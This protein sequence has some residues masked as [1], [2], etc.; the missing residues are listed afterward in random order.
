MDFS[1]VVL[2]TG[3]IPTQWCLGIICP[4]Y[5]K[6]GSIEELENYRGITLLCCTLFT[7]CLYSTSRRLSLYE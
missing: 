5:K 7:A 6:K 3:Y 1:N 4:I 2:S